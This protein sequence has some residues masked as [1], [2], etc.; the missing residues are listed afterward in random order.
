MI[1]YYSFFMNLDFEIKKIEDDFNSF[2]DEK[3]KES[4]GFTNLEHFFNNALNI[5]LNYKFFEE[6]VITDL[7]IDINNYAILLRENDAFREAEI[8]R[9][10][11]Y[12]PDFFKSNPLIKPYLNYVRLN[13]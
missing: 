4:D 13:L 12:F 8:N 1:Y 5:L 10:G 7:I 2:K 3:K 9:Q 6:K 11:G